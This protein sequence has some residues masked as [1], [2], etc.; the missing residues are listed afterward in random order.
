MDAAPAVEQTSARFSPKAF[1]QGLAVIVAL[2]LLL[3]VWVFLS[4]G[5]AKERQQERLASQTVIVEWGDVA[6]TVS[7]K[8]EV[9]GPPR[10]ENMP[11][12]EYQAPEYMESGLIDAPIDGLYENTPQGHKPIIRHQDSLT[13]FKAYRRPFDVYGADGPVIAIA[14]AGLGLSDVAT[15]SAV[16]TMPPEIS[17]IV[18]PYA[19]TI[20]FWVRESRSR[21]HEIW[22]SLPTE[23]DDYPARDPG[24]HTM[25]VS[26]PERENQA[27]MEWLMTRVDGYIGFVTG[28]NPVFIGSPNDMRPIVGNIYNSGLAFVD[29]SAD[30]SLIPQTMAVGMKAPYS[31]IDIWIDRPEA[32]QEEIA[33]NLKALEELAKK[34]GF[35]VGVIQPLPVSYQQVLKWVNTLPRKNLVLAPLSATTGY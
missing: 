10:E 28:Y 20:D 3:A 14:I 27:K 32:T 33:R 35:A 1:S 6:S 23:S 29:G 7:V 21:G 34:R 30:P 9:Y 17:F 15:E 11:N 4:S 24:P 12:L 31:T 8:A 19:E 16:R 25:L 13:S 5:T 18:S 2:L 22:L 26:A